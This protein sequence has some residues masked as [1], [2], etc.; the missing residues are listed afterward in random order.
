MS[1]STPTMAPCIRPTA[2]SSTDAGY[3]SIPLKTVRPCVVIFH[4]DQRFAMSDVIDQP[5]RQMEGIFPVW[6]DS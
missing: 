1:P 2:V 5:S 6:H 4:R 3:H